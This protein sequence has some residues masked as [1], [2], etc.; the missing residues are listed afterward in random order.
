MQKGLQNDLISLLE[1]NANVAHG[2][3]DLKQRFKLTLDRARLDGIIKELDG[4]IQVLDRL[5]NTMDATREATKGSHVRKSS[6]T[7]ASIEATRRQVLKLCSS[8]GGAMMKCKAHNHDHPAQL[9]V[10]SCT[11]LIASHGR[12]KTRTLKPQQCFQLRIA[13]TSS[14]PSLLWHETK[15]ELASEDLPASQSAPASAQNVVRVQFPNIIL[16]QSAGASLEDIDNLCQ[17][18]QSLGVMH[19]PLQ[20]CIYEAGNI[21]RRQESSNWAGPMT[22]LT[23]VT[24]EQSLSRKSAANAVITPAMGLKARMIL[25]L[26]LAIALLHVYQTPWLGKN[27]SKTEVTFLQ[28][29]SVPGSTTTPN[30]RIRFDQPLLSHNF[31]PA[32]HSVSSSHSPRPQQAILQLAIMLL[33][34]WHDETIE[35]YVQT[36]VPHDHWARM[37]IVSAWIGDTSNEPLP[38]YGDAVRHCLKVSIFDPSWD[39]ADFR[40]DYCENI[41]E[42]L[43]QSCEDWLRKTL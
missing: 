26:N 42:P 29:S 21:A 33:E 12:L 11:Q 7:A 24:L 28:E 5:Q 40:R 6:R 2:R 15:V 41:I 17:K 25:A 4:A 27:W 34:L 20:L 13:C 31:G 8:V 39:D 3:L 10:D 38:L 14:D 32:I 16:P 19:S 43:R 37:Q 18:L 9:Y 22:A 35:A 30:A 36:F 23:T 1:A